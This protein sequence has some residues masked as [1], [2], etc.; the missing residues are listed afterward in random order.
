MDAPTKVRG[1]LEAI[2]FAPTVT[3]RFDA[4]EGFV[5]VG[6]VSVKLEVE[7]PDYDFITRPIVR[8]L[9]EEALPNRLVAHMM[10]GAQL[11]YANPDTL[12][13]DRYAPDRS[14]MAVI[15][16]AEVTLSVLLH[17]NPTAEYMAEFASY[18][19]TTRYHLIDDP[20]N[21]KSLVFGVCEFSVGPQCSIGGCTEKRLQSWTK[22]AGGKFKKFFSAPVVQAVGDIRPPPNTVNTFQGV[23]EWLEPQVHS[24]ASLFDVAITGGKPFPALVV[25]APNAIIGFQIE[26]SN[27]I[28][29]AEKKGFRKKALPALWKSK[30]GQL[31]LDR[32][33]GTLATTDEITARNLDGTPPLKGKRIALIG[34]GTIG[35]YLAR[36][37][38]QLGAGFDQRLLVID[39]DT[40]Q[41]ENLG[42]HILGSKYLGRNK[43]KALA[44]ALKADFP[45]V[46]VLAV[47]SPGQGS[48]ARLNAY[49][50]VVDTTGEETFS[51]ALNAFA[52]ASDV[53]NRSFPPILHALIFGNGIA[54]QTYLSTRA[55]KKA[56][57]RCLKPD[58]TGDWR[59]SPVK[60]DAALAK[61]AI[62]ACTYGT[63]TPFGVSASLSAAALASQHIT[64]FF[65][66]GYSGDLRTVQIDPTQSRSIPWKTVSQ[67]KQCPACAAD[68][69]TTNIKRSS[70]T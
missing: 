33:K 5:K 27:L 21:N 59:N 54:A 19:S 56:C 62:R 11:C 17:S 42:R 41:P 64:D 46:E 60:P 13:L 31:T 28:K 16:Q 7:I 4:Y 25:A 58:F 49:D 44:E 3:R 35:G 63:F 67:S 65:S 57:Y 2:G 51:Q 1:A 12:L 32:F 24:S 10:E 34:A 39:Q 20:R 14:I 43:A 23:V 52:I 15:K 22:D 18:W 68:D 53:E 26:R 55:P 61:L 8:V 45:D 38:I 48:F 69:T 9:N 66:D 36:S 6:K 50:I 40:L 70:R 47:S 30:A 29:Q 37:L